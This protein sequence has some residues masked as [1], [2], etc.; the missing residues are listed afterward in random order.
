VPACIAGPGQD[1]SPGIYRPRR[2]E[3]SILHRL[4]R[5]HLETFL[6]LARQDDVDIDAV[7]LCSGLAEARGPSDG[8]V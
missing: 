4:V 5:E 2:P 7:P 8:V 1:S 3:Q 6:A